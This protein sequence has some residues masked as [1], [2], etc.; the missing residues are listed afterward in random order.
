MLEVEATD[1]HGYMATRSGPNILEAEKAK[2]TYYIS[3][4]KN[5]RDRPMVTS[6][7]E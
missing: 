2:K 6:E 5:K 4:S 1:H 7:C 3:I